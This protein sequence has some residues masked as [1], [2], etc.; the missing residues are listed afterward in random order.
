MILQT[1]PTWR[2]SVW[3]VQGSPTRLL[4][5]SSFLSIWTA[6]IL[7][8]FVLAV[9]PKRPSTAC[10]TP[11]KTPSSKIPPPLASHDPGTLKIANIPSQSHLRRVPR[12]RVHKRPGCTWEGDA[13]H[14]DHTKGRSR[15]SESK[16][17]KDPHLSRG[18]YRITSAS[19]GPPILGWAAGCSE[20]WSGG[21]KRVR[22]EDPTLL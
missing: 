11:E 1:P 19:T 18:P 13:G 5:F 21:K 10:V 3:S 17:E 8:R 22:Q 15:V 7:R 12:L 16:Q 4:G 14:H 6:V 2:V 20:M 9:C